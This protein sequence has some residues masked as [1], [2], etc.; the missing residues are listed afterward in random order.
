MQIN[1]ALL[2]LLLISTP[3][4]FVSLLLARFASRFLE[5]CLVWLGLACH[6]LEASRQSKG[7][8][9]GK[10]QPADGAPKMINQPTNSELTRCAVTRK[11]HAQVF[12][13]IL[14]KPDDKL[15]Y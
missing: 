12:R 4:R 10:T 6:G 13:Q 1:L 14:Q 2:T 11:P 3:A 15:I 7:G 9:H 5:S 8:E